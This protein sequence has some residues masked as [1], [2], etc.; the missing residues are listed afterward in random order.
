MLET[1]CAL[2]ELQLSVPKYWAPPKTCCTL[3]SAALPGTLKNVSGTTATLAVLWP[4]AA[5][6]AV[7]SLTSLLR[8]NSLSL[9]LSHLVLV[10]AIANVARE[11]ESDF[12][13]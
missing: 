12:A 2:K 10:V 6:A 13:I 4:T 11:G 9:S 5:D 7:F 3:G 8:S 1:E